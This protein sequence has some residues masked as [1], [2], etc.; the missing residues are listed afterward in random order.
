MYINAI[1]SMVS[2][3]IAKKNETRRSSHHFNE[4]SNQKLIGQQFIGI[5]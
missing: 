1:D 5:G 3:L 4:K 2:L